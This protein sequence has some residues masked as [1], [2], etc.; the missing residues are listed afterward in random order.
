MQLVSYLSPVRSLKA[1]GPSKSVHHEL[2]KCVLYQIMPI[3]VRESHP[4]TAYPTVEKQKNNSLNDESA[5]IRN[6]LLQRSNVYSPAGTCI[7]HHGF[8]TLKNVPVVADSTCTTCLR[9]P[10][11]RPLPTHS[12]SLPSR[13]PP[14][15]LAAPSFSHFRPAHAFV[16]LAKR[17]KSSA[18]RNARVTSLGGSAL[19]PVPSRKSILM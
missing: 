6:A 3:A 11:P 12:A 19:G 15:A 16:P 18:S 13:P 2:P 4:P 10:F 7:P 9:F 14:P 1:I 8:L 5:R 17:A